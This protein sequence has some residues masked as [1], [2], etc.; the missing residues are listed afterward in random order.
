MVLINK[1]PDVNRA[2]AD[3]SPYRVILIYGPE[4]GLV[5][6]RANAICDV[7]S[8]RVQDPFC[9]ALLDE[10]GLDEAVLE[11]ELASQSLT[12]DKR[13]VHIRLQSEGKAFKEIGNLLEQHLAGDFN[14]DTVVLIEAPNLRKDNAV[15]GITEKTKTGAAAI[16]CY[17]DRAQDS[18]QL[19]REVLAKDEITITPDAV[20][21]LLDL[22]PPHRDIIR[23]EVEKL[24]LYVGK[25]AKVSAEDV[26][27]LI[28]LEGEAN[29][30]D[31]AFLALSGDLKG[32]YRSLDLAMTSGTPATVL[33]RILSQNVSKVRLGNA[34]VA[35]GK[36]PKEAAKAQRIFWK[37]EQAFF[38]QLRAW[39]G[40][41]GRELAHATMDLDIACKRNYTMA[42]TLVMRHMLQTAA[43]AKRFR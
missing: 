23:T 39:K 27:D 19:V 26:Q 14:P 20:Q 29:A 37:Q 30:F 10:D 17:E 34:D 11:N 18:A 43:K 35:G 40:D 32:S 4:R 21:T 38:A 25:A 28:V 16:A 42:D 6:E 3:P 31:G 7:Y 12:G 1:K 24:A 41:K 22:L 33:T 13:L 2:L 15:R 5:R 9:Y 8:D 36:T